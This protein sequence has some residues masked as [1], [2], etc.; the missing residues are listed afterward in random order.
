MAGSKTFTV[1]DRVVICDGKWHGNI[2]AIAAGKID[3]SCDDGM[4]RSIWKDMALAGVIDH[5]RD[6]P[7][8]RCEIDLETGKMTILEN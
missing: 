3:V 6:M 1:G 8:T 4:T 2:K 7:K 5:E